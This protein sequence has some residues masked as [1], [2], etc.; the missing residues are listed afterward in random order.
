[1][2]KGQQHGLLISEKKFEALTQHNLKKKKGLKIPAA[3]MRLMPLT[4]LMVNISSR[5]SA[6]TLFLLAK[7]EAK[8]QMLIISSC[9]P[10]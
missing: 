4:C 2:P 3:N 9:S 7:A 6:H 8:Q 10:S 1:M 5:T